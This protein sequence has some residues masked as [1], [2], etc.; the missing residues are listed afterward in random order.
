MDRKLFLWIVIGVLLLF[1]LFLM[2]KVGA[3][4]GVQSVSGVAK[5]VASSSAMVGGC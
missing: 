3:S 2:F 1:A 4:G 5:S